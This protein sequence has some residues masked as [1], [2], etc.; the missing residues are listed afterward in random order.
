MCIQ[1][2]KQTT[3]TFAFRSYVKQQC[4]T[5]VLHHG[6]IELLLFSQ[7]PAQYHA[8]VAADTGQQAPH[9]AVLAEVLSN[10]THSVTGQ[11]KGYHTQAH[12]LE[13][14]EQPDLPFSRHLCCCAGN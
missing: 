3:Q 6:A 4:I 5:Y 11:D 14:A 10:A 12:V 9:H 13:A 1:H 8:R 2:N 7:S